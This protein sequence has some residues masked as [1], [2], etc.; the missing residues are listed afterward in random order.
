MRQRS[1]K[2][3]GERNVT[4]R[5][6]LDTLEALAGARG[7]T[8]SLRELSEQ[9]SLPKA[10]VHRLL[11]T[12]VDRGYAA[13]DTLSGSGYT[14]GPRCYYGLGSLAARYGSLSEAAADEMSKINRQLNEL[15]VLAI[16]DDGNVVYIQTCKSTQAVFC[17][18]YVGFRAPATCV[19]TGRALLAF[20]TEDEI[21]RVL[22]RPI[23]R[24]SPR[25]VV[26]AAVIS[27]LLGDARKT[28]VAV[29]YGSYREGVGGV[30]AVIRDVSARVVASVGLCLPEYRMDNGHMP[31]LRSAVLDA[32]SQISR[33]LGYEPSMDRFG[34]VTG[35]P[36]RIA[37]RN[38]F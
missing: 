5:R 21:D 25:T 6:A 38:S 23:Q 20:Q 24:Y 9:V 28:G 4:L 10:T 19:S 32:A 12:L 1:Q 34:T 30:S 17:E 2:I 33:R 37:S 11:V 13:C 36:E 18:S 8:R 26:E 3:G 27:R 15:T 31:N 16:Y 7:G 35:N 29:N 14:L 22:K